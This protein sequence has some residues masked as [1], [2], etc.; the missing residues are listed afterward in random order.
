MATILKKI[1]EFLKRISLFKKL[2]KKQV[3][4]IFSTL[5]FIVL[6]FPVY[7]VYAAEGDVWGWIARIGRLLIGTQT[8]IL[9]GIL[10]LTLLLG[11]AL[12]AASQ[13]L[14]KWAAGNPFVWSYT[15]PANN[16]IIKIGWTFLRDLTNMFFILGLAY[17]GLKTALDYGN[18]FST[19][20]TFIN[21]LIVA[22]LIN[23]SP[24]ICGVV[25]DA[26][27]ILMN[28]FT[29]DIKINVLGMV[30][31]GGLAKQVGSA[32]LASAFDGLTVLKIAA[33]TAY[34]YMAIFVMWAFII[35]FLARN[36]AIWLLVILSPLAFFAGIFDDTRK[37]F[38]T[39]KNQFVQW[40]FVGAVAGFGLY[41]SSHI[42]NEFGKGGMMTTPLFPSSD[43][44]DI[45]TELAPYSVPLLFM[46]F[47]FVTA[48]KT[49]AMGG[50]AVLK[51]VKIVEG[52][53][54]K[55]VSGLATKV[56]SD[57]MPGMAGGGFQAIGGA[58]GALATGKGIKGAVE[59][60]QKGK[61]AGVER[62]E[63]ARKWT[64][65]AME[66]IGL[67]KPGEYERAKEKRFKYTD[68]RKELD[69]ATDDQIK[70]WATGPAVTTERMARKALAIEKQIK[71]G[72]FDY[73]VA[74]AEQMIAYMQ[75][76]HKELKMADKLKKARPDLIHLIDT[77]NFDRAVRIRET[78]IN[79]AT[80]ANYT[81]D[82]AKEVVRLDMTTEQARKIGVEDFSKI[83]FDNLLNIDPA[84]D[85]LANKA[86]AAILLGIDRGKLKKLGE[87]ASTI[88][89]QAI[90]N[91]VT[92]PATYIPGDPLTYGP[93][94]SAFR[95]LME[96]AAL[97]PAK[98]A[99]IQDIISAIHGD[100]NFK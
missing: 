27:N 94:D 82:Q 10:H 96:Q 71:E 83:D 3:L 23:F 58:I 88:Q 40:S 81:P 8:V 25:V 50:N 19:Q 64:H 59:G 46:L 52:K 21:L 78:Q 2:P 1:S 68:A 97:S 15:N 91:M 31:E 92:P 53:A 41:L 38:N 37:H 29:A 61:E 20:K 12:L 79:P 32:V 89:K 34:T 22:L 72:D 80:G 87:T 30:Y 6:L 76:S 56:K 7:Y 99:K 100:P 18:K 39:W 44:S 17:I 74:E 11:E 48:L 36:V 47:T 98:Q 26:S 13:A 24:V 57:V 84:I 45:F 70:A 55:G 42:I 75:K 60:W 28:Y 35:L 69:I 95:W 77:E 62:A 86:T 9:S 63:T 93:S 33:L 14:L 85:P 4:L 5:S 65:K 43:F 49:S 73:D 66:T 16:P 51:G 54:R 67:E 90:K